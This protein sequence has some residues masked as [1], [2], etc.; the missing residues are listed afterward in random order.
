MVNGES[1]KIFQ[2]GG[3]NSELK[4]WGHEEAS[5]RRVCASGAWCGVDSAEVGL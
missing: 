4:G 5:E 2:V 3:R 1:T